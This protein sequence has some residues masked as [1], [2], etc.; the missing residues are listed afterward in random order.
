MNKFLFTSLLTSLFL[1]GHTQ[2]F[3][4][5]ELINMTKMNIDDFDTYASNKGFKFLETT[6]TEQQKGITYA[7]NQ[8]SYSK[9]AD[10]FISLFFEYFGQTNKNVTYQ[11]SKTEEYL[12]IK[13][14]IKPLGFTFKETKTFNGSTFLVY[15]KGKYEIILI[16]FQSESGNGAASVGYEIS[17]TYENE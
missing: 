1:V 2:S 3:S 17:V 11:T 7:F 5:T 6:D 4:L 15:T 8:S 9:K 14:Q 12:K 13:N 10:K 16:S